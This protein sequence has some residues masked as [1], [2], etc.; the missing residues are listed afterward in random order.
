MTEASLKDN[1]DI[2]LELLEEM[3]SAGR[4][5]VSEGAQLR[6]L[7]VPLSQLTKVAATVG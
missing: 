5:L 4:P 7:V 3:L 6:E 1:F 2:V